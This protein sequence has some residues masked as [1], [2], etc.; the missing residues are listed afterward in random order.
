MLEPSESQSTWI[1]ENGA[2]VT[3]N[4]KNVVWSWWIF[5]SSCTAKT[6]KAVI[7][8]NLCRTND[9]GF[10]LSRRE[11]WIS[12]QQPPL[13]W[14][15]STW[16]VKL[17]HVLNCTHQHI[18][19]NSLLLPIKVQRIWTHVIFVVSQR[20]WLWK[21]CV[22][23]EM[24]VANRVATSS[25]LIPIFYQLS[26]SSCHWYNAPPAHSVFK[27]LYFHNQPPLWSYPTDEGSKSSRMDSQ[28]VTNNCEFMERIVQSS[29]SM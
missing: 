5:S 1:V 17:R 18:C 11:L 23:L 20:R 29:T 13:S 6:V 21:R 12:G 10:V 14:A 24:S 25:V 28:L 9:I 15:T 8:S 27:N 22:A 7:L 4:D 26:K 2:D 3:E 19:H 16:N